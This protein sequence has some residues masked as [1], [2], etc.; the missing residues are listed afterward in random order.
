MDSKVIVHQKRGLGAGWKAWEF[1]KNC[2]DLGN[3]TGMYYAV[4]EDLGLN[5]LERSQF[6]SMCLAV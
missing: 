3:S 2:R 5:E 4:H 6:C 1:E